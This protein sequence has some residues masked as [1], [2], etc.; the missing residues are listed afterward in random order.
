MLVQIFFSTSVYVANSLVVKFY[1]KCKYSSCIHFR[2]KI[3]FSQVEITPTPLTVQVSAL[4]VRPPGTISS[5]IAQQELHTHKV[6]VLHHRASS[7]TI[8][9][10]QRH[11]LVKFTTL[12]KDVK[13]YVCLKHFMV[14]LFKEIP[15]GLI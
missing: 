14:C 8:K 11:L 6:H 13:F 2:E 5:P 15:K 3:D 4:P 9:Y 7:G 12:P 1:N 10:K